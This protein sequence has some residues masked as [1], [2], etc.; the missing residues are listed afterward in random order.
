MKSAEFLQC[1]D[2]SVFTTTLSS[3]RPES[4]VAVISCL[5]NFV[6]DCEG[7]SSISK[8]VEPRIQSIFEALSE[9]CSQ[10]PSRAYMVSPPMYRSSPVWYRDGLPE[11]LTVVSQIFNED[12]PGNLHL[13]PSFPLLEFED[14]GV[15]LTAYSGLEHILHLLDSSEV[16][17]E[18]RSLPLDA[19][20]SR[21]QETTRVLEDR[22]TVLEQDHRRLNK[23]VDSR[24]AIDAELA[25][26]RANERLE[27]YIVISGLRKL[28][29]DL[30]GK[31]WQ[32]RALHDVQEVIKA[33]MGSTR[34]VIVVQNATP[35]FKDADVTY[36]VR[37]AS[38]NDARTIRRTFGS[39]FK[40]G[41]DRRPEPLKSISVANRV[42]PETKI[43][44]S[45]MKLIAQRYKDSN[46]GSQAQ[47]VGY[48]P[49]PLLRVTPPKGASE[50]RVR[51]YNFIEA[52]KSFPTNFTP[53]QIAPILKRVNPRLAGQLRSTF[54]VLSDD[55]FTQRVQGPASRSSASGSGQA[56]GG[57]SSDQESVGGD[58]PP[59]IAPT[60]ARTSTREKTRKNKRGPDVEAGS[61]AKK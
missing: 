33:I 48:E 55:A 53:A 30:N 8:R 15:H 42:T 54:V 36:N 44:I 3:I 50:R 37:L 28:P 35:R 45:I 6:S 7:T 61:A 49:R 11:I 17:L 32:A 2:Y 59:A 52:V 46:P 26:Y 58:Q 16:I 4:N 43:R 29:Q 12:K 51:T 27:D 57:V 24:I 41:E 21:N 60:P 40:G 25:D 1:M 23:V 19:K 5:S 39:F 9:A 22:V 14:D 20:S 10:N 34:E 38:V 31:D 56:S 47:V 18:A 13:L